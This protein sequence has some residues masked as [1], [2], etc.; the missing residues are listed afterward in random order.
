MSHSL[1]GADRTT[2]LKIAVVALVAAAVVVGTGINSR[3]SDTGGITAGIKTNG[4]VVK[5]GKPAAY[6]NR[7]DSVVR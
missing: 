4:T 5:A 2:H 7:G 1:L 3:I 6:T